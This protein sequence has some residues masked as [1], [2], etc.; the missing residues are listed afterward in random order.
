MYRWYSPHFQVLEIN[1]VYEIYDEVDSPEVEYP[2]HPPDSRE[3]RKPLGTSG[4]SGSVG[5]YGS[6]ASDGKV[7]GSIQI[8]TR[9]NRVR[10]PQGA[11]FITVE[12]KSNVEMYPKRTEFFFFGSECP[13]V[14]NERLSLELPMCDALC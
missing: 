13:D 11:R 12:R 8:K 7:S 9:I 10:F 3:G 4:P 14:V 6:S 2:P 5:S 1:I